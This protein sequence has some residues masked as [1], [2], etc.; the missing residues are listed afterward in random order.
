[1]IN[2]SDHN[3][4][5]TK[6]YIS[7]REY[8]NQFNSLASVTGSKLIFSSPSKSFYYIGVEAVEDCPYSIT[9]SQTVKDIVMLEKG[10]KYDLE[11]E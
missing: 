10:K 8:P 5:C 6:I 1:M 2:I 9:L 7:D 4:H 3:R 11:L